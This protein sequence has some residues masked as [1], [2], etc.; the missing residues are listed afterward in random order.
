MPRFIDNGDNTVTD[1]KTNL[2]WMKEDDGKER[3]W[4][5]AVTYCEQNEAKLP[6][7]GWRLPTV[8]ELFTL[9]DFTRHSP[10]IDPVFS[11]TKSS[12][13]WTSSPHASYSGY[14]WYVSFYNGYVNW[15]SAGYE[16][17]VRP[18]RQNS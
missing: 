9:V 4:K 17:Y 6:G 16:Y 11:N 18:V 7:E 14:A 2:V 3:T 1:S 13:Y 12:W 5:D 15:D 10:A 8:E